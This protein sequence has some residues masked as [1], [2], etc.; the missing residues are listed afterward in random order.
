VK[1]IVAGVEYPATLSTAEV[2]ALWS[3]SPDLLQREVG[4]GRLP[5][6]P[7]RLGK[8]YRWPTLLVARAIGLPAV[9]AA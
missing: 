5:V 2:A 9:S 7:L 6:E 3:C 4:R 8:R 1:V